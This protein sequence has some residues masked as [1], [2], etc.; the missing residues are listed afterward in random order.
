MRRERW[1]DPRMCGDGGG[2]GGEVD[3]ESEAVVEEVEEVVEVGDNHGRF[4]SSLLRHR[5]D[6]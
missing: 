5:S 4:V 2:S 6:R 1:C 3:E